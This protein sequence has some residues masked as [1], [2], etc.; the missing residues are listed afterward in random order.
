MLVVGILRVKIISSTY[1]I[2]ISFQ[3]FILGAAFA[4]GNGG[5][6]GGGGCGGKYNMGVQTAPMGGYTMR[7]REGTF[8]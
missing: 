4:D 2:R 1:K 6:S 5:G 8:R 3:I 7:R